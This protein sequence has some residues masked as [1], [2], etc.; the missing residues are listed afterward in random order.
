MPRQRGQSRVSSSVPAAAPGQV[1]VEHPLLSQKYSIPTPDLQRLERT[2]RL[3]HCAGLTGGVLLGTTRIGKTTA[4]DECIEHIKEILQAP[5]F[6]VRI[7]WKSSQRVTDRTVWVRMLEGLDYGATAGRTPD[8]LERVL[9]ERLL[10]C[11][12]EAGGGHCVLFI[13]DAQWLTPFEYQQ[14]C[15][16]FNQLRDHEIALMVLLIGQPELRG[17]RT[18]LRQSG[19]TQ[20]IGRFMRAEFMFEGIRGITDLEHLL[21]WFD[22]RSEYPPGSGHSYLRSF[23]PQ[24]LQCGFRLD[25]LAGRLWSAY[26]EWRPQHTAD[27]HAGM[28]SSMSMMTFSSAVRTLL[29]ELAPRDGAELAVDDQLLAAIMQLVA[30]EHG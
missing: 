22:D 6:A 5:C 21:A 10:T 23:I 13:D 11:A 18:L 26:A 9:L 4:V 29:Q 2:L 14:L 27:R 19:D 3:W 24:A 12:Y 20:V 17:D 1:S 7:N 16:L 28:Q 15:H 8:Q 30:S 25:R